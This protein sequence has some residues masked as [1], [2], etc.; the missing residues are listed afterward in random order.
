MSASGSAAETM[1]ATAPA[2]VHR[3]Q[4]IEST[5][6]GKFA[7]AAI[8]NAS[9]TMKATFWPLNVM[10]SRIAPTPSRIVAIRE[11]R[12]CSLASAWA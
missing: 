1:L 11:T 5:R 6:A 10:P 4:K 3:R 12:S 7:L 2:V 9:D 8:A